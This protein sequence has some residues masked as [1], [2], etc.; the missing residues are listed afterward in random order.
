[1][2]AGRVRDPARPSPV[3]RGRT[4]VP[5]QNRPRGRRRARASRPIHRRLCPPTPSTSQTHPAPPPSQTATG[6]LVTACPAGHRHSR[7]P[8]PSPNVSRL[9]ASASTPLSVLL[10]PTGPDETR[11]TVYPSPA[12]GL[13]SVSC[14]V[15][16][17]RRDVRTALQQN[18]E[19]SGWSQL[20]F[21]ESAHGILRSPPS[22]PWP[23]HAST[24]VALSHRL[25]S[26]PGLAAR[27]PAPHSWMRAPTAPAV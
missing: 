5:P 4:L 8:A 10:I 3:H 23:A 16:P 17:A 21:T 20:E 14:T 18:P 19:T 12:C 11:C 6:S 7:I 13:V 24:V 1:M 15:E 9:I 2:G 26:P 22:G 27:L 25:A